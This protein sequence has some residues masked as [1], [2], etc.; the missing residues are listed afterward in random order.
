[1]VRLLIQRAVILTRDPASD[2]EIETL[3]KKSSQAS[4]RKLVTANFVAEAYKLSPACCQRV[5][6]AKLACPF[7]RIAKPVLHSFRIA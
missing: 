6:F 5:H 4:L 3:Q 1:V 7:G 2:I